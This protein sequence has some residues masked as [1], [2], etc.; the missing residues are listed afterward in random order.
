MGGWVDGWMGG[1]VDGWMGGWVVRRRVRAKENKRSE[2]E[3][4]RFRRE[5]KVH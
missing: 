1:W 3:V 2:R 5:E 4:E